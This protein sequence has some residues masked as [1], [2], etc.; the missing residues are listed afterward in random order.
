M[1]KKR[2]LDN[3]NTLSKIQARGEKTPK[4][5]SYYIKRQI[6]A[7]SNEI[8]A[9]VPGHNEYL[10]AELKDWL[11]ACIAYEFTVSKHV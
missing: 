8:E 10:E 3:L 9:L 11:T 1:T 7:T 4:Q 2:V 5:M 6:S